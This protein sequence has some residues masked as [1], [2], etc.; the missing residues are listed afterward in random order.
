MEGFNYKR[1]IPNA[2]EAWMY[3]KLIPRP[4]QLQRYTHELRC[5]HGFTP[6][7]I[8]DALKGKY[9]V[10]Q[11]RL[12]THQ[13]FLIR[14]GNLHSIKG[15]LPPAHECPPKHRDGDFD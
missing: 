15:L 12:P 7:Q 14:D 9:I 3:I 1:N 6:Q 4:L 13:H 2:P 5:K 10:K 11:W 8:Y